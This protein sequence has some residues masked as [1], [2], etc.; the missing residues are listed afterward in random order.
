MKKITQKIKDIS[1]WCILNALGMII[2]AAIMAA[3]LA[4]SF[5]I[6]FR[7]GEDRY[8]YNDS[9]FLSDVDRKREKANIEDKVDKLL[10]IK[11]LIYYYYPYDIDKE[12]LY[13]GIYAGLVASLG[14]EYSYYITA[15]EN[16]AILADASGE[17]YGVGVQLFQ[18]YDSN[19]IEILMVYD[20]GPAKKAGI[21]NG[22]KLVS[23]DGEKV[24]GK[25]LSSISNLI[26]GPKD[27][28]VTLEI[29][30]NGEILAFSMTRDN[31]E[32]E[33]A[34]WSD[35]GDN[36]AYL[37]I[38]SFNNQHLGEQMEKAI[39]E[40]SAAGIN[41][42][43]LDL[44]NNPGG[45]VA[46]LEDAAKYLLPDC[47]M[48]EA[49]AKREE[50]SFTINSIGSEYNFNIT[51]LVDEYTASS[52]EILAGALQDINGSLII[53]EQTYGKGVAQNHL[54]LFDGSAVHIT[55]A[56]IFRPNG[57]SLNNIGVIPDI[58][59]ESE[60]NSIV[61]TDPSKDT[62]VQRAKFEILNERK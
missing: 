25:D 48:A 4:L 16:E 49:R 29:E 22:D 60:F 30:R 20:N 40:I 8:L 27:S 52:S 10:D 21:L 18:E 38:E 1:I 12:K 44:R 28:Q 50:S 14:D 39:E 51:C 53:G 62:L 5:Y 55:F 11:D 41:D 15:E 19:E 3:A 32:K 2:I 61:M 43:V 46:Y 34:Y 57:E 33:E 45:T 56:E 47:V 42:I 23:V 59:M 54:M 36:I 7:V 9:N 6:G 35:I 26:S 17:Y 31:V 13:E 58:E 24:I 37:R